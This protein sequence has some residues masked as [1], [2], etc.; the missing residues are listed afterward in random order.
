MA[1]VT[2]PADFAEVV[3]AFRV[4]PVTHIGPKRCRVSVEGVQVTRGGHGIS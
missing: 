3:Q 1:S 4:K 2:I